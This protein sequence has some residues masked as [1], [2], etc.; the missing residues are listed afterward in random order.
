MF[1][2]PPTLTSSYPD[3]YM[4]TSRGWLNYRRLLEYLILI[5]K[6][7]EFEPFSGGMYTGTIVDNIHLKISRCLIFGPYAQTVCTIWGSP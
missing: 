4:F 1:N 7:A 2:S 5:L 6:Y 3:E